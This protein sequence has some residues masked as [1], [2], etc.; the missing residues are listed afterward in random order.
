LGD[1]NV[2]FHVR[3]PKGTLDGPN[4]I[5]TDGQAINAFVHDAVVAVGGSISAEHGIG[6]M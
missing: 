6:Q 1:G 4:W 2:H 5:A 3:A